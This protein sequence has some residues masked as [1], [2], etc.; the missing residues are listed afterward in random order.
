MTPY[1]QVS[2]D[3]SMYAP[4]LSPLKIR[5]KNMP[6]GSV[7]PLIPKHHKTVQ[8][9]VEDLQHRFNLPKDLNKLDSLNLIIELLDTRQL[10]IV[11][12]PATPSHM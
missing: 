5:A 12:R 11:T 1:S 7:I 6:D 4:S 3:S 8:S 2:Y 10:E 9:A